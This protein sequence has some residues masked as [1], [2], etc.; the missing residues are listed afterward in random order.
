[1]AR[2]PKVVEDR[3]EQIMD[4]ALRVFAQKGFDKATNKD[5]AD[6]AGI[7]PGLIYHYF[8]SK[9][10]LLKAILEEHSPLRLVHVVTE[11]MFD[12]PPHTL[13]RYV[14]HQL[15]NIVE[16]EHYVRLARIFLAEAIHHPGAI[17]FSFAAMQEVVHFLE[18]YLAAKMDSGELRRSDPSLIVQVFGG[19]IMALVLHRQIFHNP[20]ALQYS[21]EQIV[22]HVVDL[23]LQG[24][25]PR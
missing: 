25:L 2:T 9:E 19:S 10:K 13:L 23:T 7:T 11:E 17:S 14:A 16:D 18:G 12:M 3:R 24:L 5:I 8:E 15:L 21:H 4:A 6:E 20:I 22:E 1:M